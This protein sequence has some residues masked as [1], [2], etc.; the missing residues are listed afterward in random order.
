MKSTR[1]EAARVV[2][3]FYV[4]A[5]CVAERRMRMLAGARELVVLASNGIVVAV[6]RPIRG[7]PCRSLR[8]C[9][10]PCAN[11]AD[12]SPAKVKAVVPTGI[13]Y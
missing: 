3:Y 12:G 1:D 10:Q 8:D 13:N 9:R 2:C 7:G 6:R 5:A 4:G 11:D